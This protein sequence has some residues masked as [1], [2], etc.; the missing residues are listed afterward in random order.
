MSQPSAGPA[1]RRARH[2]FQGSGSEEEIG[3]AP[4]VSHRVTDGPSL[5]SADLAV[6]GR[7]EADHVHREAIEAC[8]PVGPLFPMR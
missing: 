7:R 4:R 1:L 6:C 5:A 3:I 2:A 8:E